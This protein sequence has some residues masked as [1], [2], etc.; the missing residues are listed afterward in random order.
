MLTLTILILGLI[1]VSVSIHYRTNIFPR[2]KSSENSK[3]GT[4]SNYYLERNLR[5]GLIMT[6]NTDYEL[7]V[8]LKHRGGSVVTNQRNFEYQW[9]N[10]YPDQF[11]LSMT[12]FEKCTDKI[13]APCPNDH[14][15]INAPSIGFQSSTNIRVNVIRKS[16]YEVVASARFSPSIIPPEKYSTMEMTYPIG[17]EIF[18]IGEEFTIY[19]DSPSQPIDY[20]NIYYSYYED[21]EVEGGSVGTASGGSGSHQWVI[22]RTLKNKK[23]RLII[24]GRQNSIIIVRTSTPDDFLVR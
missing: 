21:G 22:P 14:L 6:T 9:S 11:A 13:K 18:R 4:S 16:T 2:A 20:Y 24:E 5:G 8:L 19:W 1:V 23:V 10:D 15:L 17:G 3:G 12:P 7:S